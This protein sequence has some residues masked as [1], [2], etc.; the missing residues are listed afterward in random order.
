MD[1]PT[2][3]ASEKG[4]KPAPPRAKIN[5]PIRHGR[6]IFTLVKYAIYAALGVDMTLFLFDGTANEALDS[7]SWL[8]LLGCFEYESVSMNEAYAGAWEKRILLG[9]QAVGYGLAVKVAIT[10]GLTEDWLDL[11]NTILW[12]L[13]CASIAYDLYAPGAFGDREWR[14]RNAIKVLLYL[15]L[16]ACTLSWGIGGDWLGFIDGALWILCFGLV[17]LNIFEFEEGELAEAPPA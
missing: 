10:Y 15:G 11:A 12:L 7:F 13:V 4:R 9:L 16:L 6:R 17:E 14:V 1:Q 8:L 2:A 5:V 3:P